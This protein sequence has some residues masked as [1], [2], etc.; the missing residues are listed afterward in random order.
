MSCSKY[1]IVHLASTCYY[2]R[3]FS[4]HGYKNDK[5]LEGGLMISCHINAMNNQQKCFPFMFRSEF[6][7]RILKLI[8][9]FVFHTMQ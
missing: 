9:T 3:S 5:Q 6:D 1:C 7:F 2:G 8:V 4:L